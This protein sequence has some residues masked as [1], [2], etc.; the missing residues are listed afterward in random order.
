[1]ILNQF[2][3]LV[4]KLQA[5]TGRKEKEA[6]LSQY[7]GNSEI[8][9]ILRYAYD[10]YIILGLSKKSLTKQ[11]PV[12]AERI[13]SDIIELLTYLAEHNT[14][15]YA[16]V[17][18]AQAFI[19]ANEIYKDLIIDTISKELRTGVQPTTLNKIFGEGFIRSFGA[20]CSEIF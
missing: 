11:V 12:E 10:P 1:M 18:Y 6:I 4:E 2:A 3:D 19:K 20:A 8:K 17:A 13:P 5:T 9:S 14:G 7:R 16:D 15:R